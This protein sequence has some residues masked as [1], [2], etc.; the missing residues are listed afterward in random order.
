MSFHVSI[1]REIRSILR[2]GE[3][4]LVY[5]IDEASRTILILKFDTRG[6]IY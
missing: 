2:L 5:E 6:D 1:N 4:R 3:C